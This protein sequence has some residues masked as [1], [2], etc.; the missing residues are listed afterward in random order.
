MDDTTRYAR[1]YTGERS[2]THAPRK[3]GGRRNRA[4]RHD[5][6]GRFHSVGRR[7]DRTER[8]PRESPP[9]LTRPETDGSEMTIEL[10]DAPNH[11]EV[12]VELPDGGLADA[13]VSVSASAVRIRAPSVDDPPDRDTATGDS[14]SERSRTVERTVALTRRVV[15]ERAEV[16]RDDSTLTVTLPKANPA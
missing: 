14:P 2:T 11:V 13:D 12:T 16:S 3:R 1:G 10:R 15:V 7:H 5:D 4:E 8:T 9:L 6:A